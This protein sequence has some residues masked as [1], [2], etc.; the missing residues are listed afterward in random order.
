MAE[1]STLVQL[2][3]GYGV[4]VRAGVVTPQKADEVYFRQLM[5]LPPMGAEADADWAVTNG[6]RS[7][8]TIKRPGEE[9]PAMPM[10]GGEE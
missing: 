1:I 10:T 2:L 8:L 7:P 9:S 5:D 3:N 6:I 4:A